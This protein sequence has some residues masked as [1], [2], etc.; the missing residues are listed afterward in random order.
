M[1]TR[2]LVGRVWGRKRAVAIGAIAAAA[3]LG[4]VQASA[5]SSAEGASGFK[6]P[7]REAAIKG[8]GTSLQGVVHTAKSSGKVAAAQL[9][10]ASGV[11]LTPDGVRVIVAPQGGAVEAAKDAVAAHGGK[12]ERSAAGLV[13]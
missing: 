3:L 4:V 11:D 13:Q 7:H 12:V 6:P 8:V 5:G 1:P 9:A 2:G 10:R